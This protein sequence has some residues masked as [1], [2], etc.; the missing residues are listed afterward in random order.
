MHE[1]LKLPLPDMHSDEWWMRVMEGVLSAYESHIWEVHLTQCAQC[2]LEWDAFRAVDQLLLT[3]PP[4][5]QLNTMFTGQT[6]ALV[7]Q[8]QRLRQL[9]NF[10]GSAFI[11]LL[12]SWG[13]LSFL[14]ATYLA[15]G[16]VLSFMFVGRQV[17]FNSLIHTLLALFN[18]WKTFLPFALFFIG[19][20]FMLLMPNG[21]L[22]TMFIFWLSRRQPAMVAAVD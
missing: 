11:V 20:G 3:A 1:N 22:A 5:P 6:T 19:V 15:L 9:L 7:M 10:L 16:R 12:V 4:P 2:R 14:G 17:L 8:K 21:M 18:G 13:V